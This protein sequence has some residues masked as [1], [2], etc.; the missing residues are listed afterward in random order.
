MTLLEY[1]IIVDAQTVNINNEWIKREQC[2]CGCDDM[3]M[4]EIAQP[5][6]LRR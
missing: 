1:A 4:F 3:I 2:R 6:R 5:K